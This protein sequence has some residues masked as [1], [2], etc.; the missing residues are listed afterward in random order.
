M[1]IAHVRAEPVLSEVEGYS[2]YPGAKPKT[3]ELSLA[4]PDAG[5]GSTRFVT[6]EG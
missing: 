6:M 1:E 3:G 2:H 5:A 4:H